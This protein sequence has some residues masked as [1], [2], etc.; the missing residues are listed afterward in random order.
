VKLLNGCFD[1]FNSYWVFAAGLTNVQVDVFVTDMLSSQT[2]HYTNPL[3]TAFQ[4]IQDSAAFKT[5]P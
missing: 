4:P 5:C 2:R 1:P 3:G